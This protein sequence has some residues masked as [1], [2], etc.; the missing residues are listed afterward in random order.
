VMVWT[1]TRCRGRLAQSKNFEVS[2]SPEAAAVLV[3][4]Q[5]FSGAAQN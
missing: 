4:A 2:A 3:C 1:D 5:G